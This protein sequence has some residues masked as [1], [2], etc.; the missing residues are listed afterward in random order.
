[1]K[2]DRCQNEDNMYFYLD[3]EVYY[4]RKCIVF[5]RINVGETV[6]KKTYT[7]FVGETHLQLEY[8]LTKYQK[9]VMKTLKEAIYNDKD[10][11]VFAATGAGKTE[12]VMEIIEEYLNGGKKVG[13]AIAR[14]QVVLEIRERMASAFKEIDVV[15]VCEGDTD[16]VDGDLI[17]CTMHQ[18][19][20]YYD[21]FD[22]L[23]MDEIDAFPYANNDVL[24]AIAQQSCRG[25]KIYLTATPDEKMLDEVK[26]G[27]IE[28]VELFVR[29][30]G[31]PLIVPAIKIGSL[32]KQTIELYLLLK[33]NHAR[34]IQ[35][36]VFV[37]TI[38]LSKQLAILFKWVFTCRGFTS[39]TILKDKLIQEYR[40]KKY[41]VLF[42]TTVL[43]RG[44]TIKGVD[45]IVYFAN[46]IVFSEASLIQ[47]VGR[48]GRSMDIPDGNAFYLAESRS[49][50]MKKSIEMIKE[51]NR[52]I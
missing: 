37:P 8:P 17:V 48:V 23:I 51:M 19:Y 34:K 14:R 43:E 52:A 42:C 5:G 9:K 16:I 40:D 41:E 35:T 30:H 3:K 6:E 31:Y 33:N 50:S 7:P 1:M 12:M 26:A 15:A 4:C 36:L 38:A 28:Q 39:K 32:T 20:R 47:I 2:C 10:V 11:L 13:I 29:P 21:C 22:L 46:H 45:V 18:L 24:E 49:D 44:I 27:N 25:N